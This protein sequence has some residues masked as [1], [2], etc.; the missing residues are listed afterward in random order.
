MLNLDK[1]S[2]EFECPKCGFYNKATIG[3]A[4]GRDVVICR[5]CK[6]NVR[7]EDSM[8]SCRKAVRQVNRAVR[9]LEDEMGQLNSM[10]SF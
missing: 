4:R 6:S 8:N 9:E 5:G 3:Q 10:L 7:M 2:F 1:Q